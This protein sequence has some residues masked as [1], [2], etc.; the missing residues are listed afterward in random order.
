MARS[1]FADAIDYDRVRLRRDAWW[2][3]QPR[4]VVMAPDGDIWFH[5]AGP[6]WCEDFSTAPVAAQGLFIHEMMH[7]YHA[8]RGGRWWLP[9]MRHPFCR[10]D[11]V[12]RPGKPFRLYGIE[13]QAEIVRHAF[14]LRQGVELPGRPPLTAYEALLP[15]TPHSL[16]Y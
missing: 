12:L 15:F 9:L 2:P 5:P 10:Y 4:L 16:S 14:L 6:H 11:Y 1:I 7:V 3:F 13:Q 8:G